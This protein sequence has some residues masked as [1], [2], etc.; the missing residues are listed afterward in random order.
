MRSGLSVVLSACTFLACGAAETTRLSLDEHAVVVAGVDSAV[1]A[2]AEAERARD[3]Q[4]A[5]AHLAPDFYMYVDGVRQ[6]YQSV[7]QQILET[8]PAMQRF[9]THWQDVEI[10]P[11]ARDVALVSFVFHDDVTDGDGNRMRLT[12]PTTLIWAFRDGDWLII[13]ADA[14]H[15]PDPP[16][17]MR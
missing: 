3:P 6:E 17:S 2:F 16:P 12:G 4:R 7:A 11:L 9:E 14:D 10:T 5:L 13:Y 1:H 15:Y 8:F